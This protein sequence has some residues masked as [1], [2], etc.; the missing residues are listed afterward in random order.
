MNRKLTC[1]VMR[2]GTSKGVYLL[3]EQLPQDNAALKRALLA[4]M[5]SPD[6]RQIDGLGAG[7]CLPVKWQWWRSPP[8]KTQTLTITSR[9]WFPARARWI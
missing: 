4:V 7:K 9:K 5:G 6:A 1:A 2:G 3:R 8:W